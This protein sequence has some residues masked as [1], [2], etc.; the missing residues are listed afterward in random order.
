MLNPLE[1]ANARAEIGAW[2]ILAGFGALSVAAAL[3]TEPS[4]VMLPGWT[5]TLLPFVMP[6][7]GFRM[8]RARSKSGG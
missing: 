4:V 2:S 7:Y 3:F 5:Y 1:A 8:A 6:A